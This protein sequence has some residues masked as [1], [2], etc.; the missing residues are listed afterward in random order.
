LSHA[1]RLLSGSAWN[2]A[3]QTLPIAVALVAIPCL[4]RLVGLERFGFIA[5]AWVLVGYASVFDLG[6]GQ[7]LLRTM[8]A[9][10]ARGD[11]DGA[12]ANGRAGL[13]LLLA[14]GLVSALLLGAATPLL[15]DSVLK[16]SGTLRG[17]ALWALPLLAASL[18]FVM[19]SAG[20]TGVL[21]A[22]Q[23]F[24]ALNLVRGALGI[25][26][27]LAPVALAGAGFVTLPTV[28]GAV[29]VLR[30]L[31]T[32]VY[33]KQSKRRC[34]FVWRAQRPAREQV[35]ELLRLGGWMAVS[36]IVGPLLTYLDRLLIAALVPVRTVG[37]YCAP[38]DLLMRVMVIPYSVVAAYFAQAAVVQPG[39][40]AASRALADISR[41]L[42]L[43]MCPVLFA[44][45]ALA[46]PVMRLWLGEEIGRQAGQVLQILVIG[47]L[48]NAL[49]QGPA[50]L[51]QAAGRPR[52][53]ALVH[54]C[55]LPLFLV[56][57]WWLTAHH[58]IVG[59]AW[60]ATTRATLDAAAVFALTRRQLVSS[61]VSWWP[62]LVPALAAL[63]LFALAW[64]C[65][66]WVSA[67]TLLLLGGPAWAAY[68]WWGL[69]RPGERVQI[70]RFVQRQKPSIG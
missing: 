26:S 11:A 27:Y 2:L 45:M 32:W 42:L 63:P 5:L 9:R 38:Y 15:V 8:V 23:E 1:P 49:A 48:F 35:H 22:H 37:I 56:L 65:R 29:F 60:A 3:G 61:A 17:E 67:G 34:G 47:V 19:L 55:E 46:A 4:V 68:G 12:M 18:P 33:A 30:A 59:T 64:W 24:K 58:G 62:A 6:V 39:S 66:D 51:I 7:A 16:V 54:L 43:V 50:T 14:F 40:V 70:L 21:N 25:A 41:Y 36:N 44:T 10:L 28:V 57:L 69:L 53:M 31:G 52:D 13:T 20:Y